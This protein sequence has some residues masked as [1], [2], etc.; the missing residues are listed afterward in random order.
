MEKNGQ[1]YRQ[2]NLV[3][4]TLDAM[5]PLALFREE[6]GEMTFP[7]WLEL[8]DVL[9]ITADLLTNRLAGRVEKSDF[10]DALLGTIGLQVAEVLVD[11][12]ATQGYVSTIRLS[13]DDEVVNVRVG[14]V[15]A[16]VAAIRFKLPV[17]ISAE[18]IASSSLVDQREVVTH[19]AGDETHLLALLERLAPEDMGKYPM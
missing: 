6:S 13:G 1:Q 10:L 16:L 2:L 12:S 11:G 3:G 18:A 5:Q 15:A 19:E 7:L 8:S 4:F 17:S 9:A 14:M